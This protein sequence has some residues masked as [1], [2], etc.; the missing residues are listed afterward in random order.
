MY[1]VFNIRSMPP[2]V[3]KVLFLYGRVMVK[4]QGSLRAD[5]QHNY[6]VLLHAAEQIFRQ[7]GASV[8]L[9]SIAKQAGVGIG[10]LYRHFP[11]RESLLQAVYATKV[12]KLVAEASTLLLSTSPDK[13]LSEWL[14]MIVDLS[15]RYD[16]FSGVVKHACSD[17]ASPLAQAGSQLLARAQRIR[18]IR[19]DITIADVLR[20]VNGVTIDMTKEDSKRVDTLIEIIISGLKTSK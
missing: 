6:D 7:N 3:K 18:L 17:D 14:Q 1:S 16:G 13:A 11:N 20:L 5:A 19:S 2:L 8:A 10:T 9:E 12:T 15:R 4:E